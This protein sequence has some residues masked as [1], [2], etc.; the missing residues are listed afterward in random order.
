MYHILD[1]LLYLVVLSL[2]FQVVNPNTQFD[3]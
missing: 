3:I 1:Y 2:L